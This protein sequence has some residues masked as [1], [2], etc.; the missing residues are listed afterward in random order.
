M[1]RHI[2]V[3]ATLGAAVAVPGTALADN[4]PI[5]PPNLDACNGVVVAA[6]PHPEGAP[7]FYA[8]DVGLPVAIALAQGRV[9]G[10]CAHP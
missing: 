8:Q 10:Q 9:D 1:Y 7:Y 3:V 5:P 6:G 2:I 4:I